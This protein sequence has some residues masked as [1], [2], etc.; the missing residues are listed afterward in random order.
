[1]QERLALAITD[2][3]LRELLPLI[4]QQRSSSA[5]LIEQRVIE[6]TAAAVAPLAEQVAELSAQLTIARAQVAEGISRAVLDE[7]LATVGEVCEGFVDRA[8]ARA[9]ERVAPFEH[10]GTF[11]ES[12]EYTRNEF[13]TH[14]GCMWHARQAVPAG[15]VPGTDR[16]AEFWTLAVKCGRDAKG[17]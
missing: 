14:K 7:R 2:A 9:F 5:A 4:E 3:L 16:G 11:E 13:V 1:M 17:A 6:A 15:M 8:V 12:R 10:V